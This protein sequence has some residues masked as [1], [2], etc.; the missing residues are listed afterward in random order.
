MIA[1]DNIDE[2]I[3]TIRDSYDNAKDRL[4]QKFG[5]TD[6]QA[7]AILDMQLRRLQGLERK[8]NR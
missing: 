7:Q 5:L 2:V 6:V 8:K 3:K 4:M 1:I